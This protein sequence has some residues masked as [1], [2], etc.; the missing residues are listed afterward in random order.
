MHEISL[1]ESILE[2]FKQESKN[3]DFQSIRA[4]FLEIGCLSC[5]EPDAIRFAFDAVMRGSLAENA[6]LEIIAVPGR[7]WCGDCAKHVAVS[8]RY[9]NCPFCGSWQLRITQGE[10]MRIKELEVV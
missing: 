6:R 2:I 3:N 9:S 7:A 5:V 10:Q 8:E 1:C 4:V